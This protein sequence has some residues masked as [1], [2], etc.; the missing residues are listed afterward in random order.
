MH[1]AAGAFRDLFQHFI[2]VDHTPMLP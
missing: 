1:R 2:I